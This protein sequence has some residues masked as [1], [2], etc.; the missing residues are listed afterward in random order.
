[1]MPTQGDVSPL[2]RE[3]ESMTGAKPRLR[4]LHTSDV[5]IGD[6]YGPR[7][8]SLSAVVNVALSRQVDAVII[9]GDL[10]DSARVPP[11]MVDLTLKELSRLRQPTI[12]IPGN[13]DCVDK[14]SIYRR[15]DLGEAGGHVHFVGDPAG[16]LLVFDE[17][18]LSVWAR[19]IEDHHPGHKPLLGHAPGDARHWRV[20]VTHGHYVPAG[21]DSFRS[22]MIRQEEIGSLEADY[23]A[24]GH[25]H[26]FLDVSH[27]GVAAFYSGSPGEDG[28]SF[29]SAN[30]VTLDPVA[31]VS[32]ERVPLRGGL[33]PPANL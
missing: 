30:L 31:G 7:L 33:L 22:S 1:M 21:E 11:E 26:R 20:V 2:E 19:G 23:V 32:V 5:H 8:G 29:A 18:A 3:H 27:N 28:S 16:K 25:W 24:L 15:G 17:L 13:H 4:L 10:F 12:V 14:D 6:G 9:A